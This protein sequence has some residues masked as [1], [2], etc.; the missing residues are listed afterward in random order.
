VV[1]AQRIV[2]DRDALKDVVGALRT[3][4]S[5]RMRIGAALPSPV[6]VSLLTDQICAEGSRGSV[7]P[8]EC[9]QPLTIP[10]T[11]L[12]AVARMPVPKTYDSS[13]CRSTIARIV[14]LETSVSDT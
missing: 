9:R 6:D 7:G 1:Q 4:L 12:M 11:R 13:A 8:V 14:E 2:A 5:G 3:G 10:T